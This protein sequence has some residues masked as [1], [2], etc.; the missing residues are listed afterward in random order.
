MSVLYELGWSGE[1]TGEDL[2]VARQRANIKRRSWSDV[3]KSIVQEKDSAELEKSLG[4]FKRDELQEFAADI[5]DIESPDT[6]LKPE[7]IQA[8]KSHGKS[9]DLDKKDLEERNKSKSKRKKE[10]QTLK[11]C[12]KS[13]EK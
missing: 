5:E 7:L 9:L 6:M 13:K 12:K 2:D 4:L 11:K 1:F 8:L 3:Q 10:S